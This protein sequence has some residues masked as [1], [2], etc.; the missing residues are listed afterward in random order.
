MMIDLTD[1]D[2]RAIHDALTRAREQMGGLTTGMVLNLIIMTDESTQYDAV[3]AASQAGREHPC[4]VLGMIARDPRAESRLDAEIRTGEGA[5]G[6]TVL[7]RMY[8]PMGRHADSVVMPLL[9]PDIPVLTWWPRSGPSAPSTDP[10]GMLAQRRV[11]DAAA[12][13]EPA[14]ALAALA[15]GYRPG[16]TDLSWT[17]ATTWRSVLAATLDQ[18][19]GEI[20]GGSV[21]AEPR[22]PSADLIA[23]WLTQRLKAPFTRELSEGPG[24]TEVR[25]AVTDGDITIARPDGR[26]AIL[27]RPGQ[28]D[29]R[30]ALHRRDTAELMAEELRRLNPDEVYGET[31]AGFA[32]GAGR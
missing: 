19:H 13:S 21:T 28:Q 29:R 3:R 17:R 15:A 5:P 9:V 26:T 7:L 20:T 18:P 1:T 30:V 32:A 24:I 10:L 23:A 12:A 27:S 16:D 31:L 22:N 4:R 25:F 6:Q 11:T 2:T 14:E 8:G